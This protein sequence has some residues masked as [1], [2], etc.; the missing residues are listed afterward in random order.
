MRKSRF[1]FPK[2][3]TVKM[4]YHDADSQPASDT[5]WLAPWNVPLNERIANRDEWHSI[6]EKLG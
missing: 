4:I 3:V 5:V 6:I 1:S 2:V